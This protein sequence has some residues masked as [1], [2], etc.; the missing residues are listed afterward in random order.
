VTPEPDAERVVDHLVEAVLG[1]QR[2]WRRDEV[3]ERS[4]VPLEEA[5][6]LWRALGFA[7]V[8]DAVAFTDDDV[9]GLT[10]LSRLLE[11]DVVDRATSL[12]VARSLGQTTSRLADWQ[13]D[14]FGRL[15]AERGVIDVDD[16]LSQESVA[17]LFRSLETLLPVLERLLVHAWRRQLAAA[18]ERSLGDL[19]A[20]ADGDD[21]GH[22]TV[23]FADQVGFTRLARHL[24]EVELAH[25]VERFET[26]AADVVAGC[27]GRLIKTLGDEVLFVAPEAAAAAEIAL[28]MLEAQHPS[29]PTLRIGLA[30]GVVV[31]RRGDVFGTTVNLASRLTSEA[32]PGAVLIDEPTAEL[33]AGDPAYRLDRLAPR[34]LRGLGSVSPVELHRRSTGASSQ[35]GPFG[36]PD[37]DE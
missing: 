2:R 7:D 1:S 32:A 24:E 21:A 26:R 36:R 11:H 4:G 19:E 29:E 23:G 28:R 5:R 16:P 15:L 9:E 27:G 14:A 18:F 20:T 3:V 10:L 12:D 25:L 6:S 17:R 22:L 34:T 13:V 31:T 35:V 8:G 37:A 33:V 30:T